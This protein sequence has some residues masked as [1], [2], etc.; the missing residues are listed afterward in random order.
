MD[1][2]HLS[3]CLRKGSIER[4]QPK[5]GGTNHGRL[6]YVETRQWQGC[7]LY[8]TNTS[9]RWETDPVLYL[10]VCAWWYRPRGRCLAISHRPV[11][12]RAF[13]SLQSFT[14]EIKNPVS[15]VTLVSVIK[16]INKSCFYK[17]NLWQKW[18]GRDRAC[19][20]KKWAIRAWDRNQ[21]D[22]DRQ[23]QANLSQNVEFNALI[24]I[25][26]KSMRQVRRVWQ[27]LFYI[28]SFWNNKYD[29]T[30]SNLWLANGWLNHNRAKPK[31]VQ[32]LYPQPWR[33][34]TPV[35]VYTFVKTAISALFV[36]QS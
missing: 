28:Y 8:Q 2:F 31:Q 17:L 32:P 4:F 29:R 10:V 21:T 9:D 11:N 3:S 6:R 34:F 26:K 27:P 30:N 20:I 36:P 12:I 1:V 7:R 15:V 25:N 14:C 35:V 13:L 24:C 16:Y 22:W 19:D 18:D 5:D 33:L 23:K